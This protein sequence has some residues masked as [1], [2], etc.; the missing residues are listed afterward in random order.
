[1]LHSGG[2]QSQSAVSP[3]AAT[4]ARSRSTARSWG[5]SPCATPAAWLI[6]RSVD[7]AEA[8]AYSIAGLY[9]DSRQAQVLETLVV[10]RE[11][12]RQEHN[13][14][15]QRILHDRVGGN[16]DAI[17]KAVLLLPNHNDDLLDEIR[18]AALELMLLIRNL[19]RGDLADLY[20][21]TLLRDGLLAALRAE[22]RRIRP[23]ATGTAR[24]CLIPAASTIR[25]STST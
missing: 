10:R 11:R 1:M 17:H 23:G 19:L 9:L 12:E 18:E 7:L 3:K 14:H 2:A 24:S 6:A 21:A 15:L 5:L 25:C 22:I 13:Q 8:C 4:P 16:L 20:P